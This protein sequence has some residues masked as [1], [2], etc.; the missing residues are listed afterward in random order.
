M[1]TAKNLDVEC[2]MWTPKLGRIRVQIL[3]FE[4]CD[5]MHIYIEPTQFTW[6]E[7]NKPETINPMVIVFNNDENQTPLYYGRFADLDFMGSDFTVDFGD[8]GLIASLV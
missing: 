4:Y 2:S 5:E 8:E 7:V 6:K 1:T 3:D